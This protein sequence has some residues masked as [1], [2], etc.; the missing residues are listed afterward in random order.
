[1]NNVVDFLCVSGSIQ[2]SHQ[3]S[4]WVLVSRT[5]TALPADVRSGT[6]LLRR[7]ELDVPSAFHFLA[8]ALADRRE[9]VFRKIRCMRDVSM[10]VEEDR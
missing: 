6:T 8:L 3:H 2:E 7:V 9:K 4:L 5:W 1:M 10:K